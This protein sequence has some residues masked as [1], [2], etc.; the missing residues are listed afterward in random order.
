MIESVLCP[1]YTDMENNKSNLGIFRMT[2]CHPLAWLF[3]GLLI[4]NTATHAGVEIISTQGRNIYRL[5]LARTGSSPKG[6]LI[7][8]STFD[9]R[10]CAFSLSGQ[11]NWDANTGGFVYDL[12]TGD[13][14]CDGSDEIVA[15]S[16]DGLVYVHNAAGAR[17]WTVDLKAPVYQVAIAK[18]DGKTPVVLAGG[19]SRQLVALS[20]EGK[21]LHSV[22]IKDAV[23]IIRSGDFNG[24]G[25]DEVAVLS[26][27]E[28][29]SFLHG[30]MLSPVNGAMLGKPSSSSLTYGSLRQANGT[31]AD[32]DGDGA[33]EFIYASGAYSLKKGVQRHFI[34]PSRFREASY[35]YH[36]NMRLLASGELT[37]QPGLETVALEG[38]QIRLFDGVGKE[39]GRTIAPFGFTDVIYLPGQP[40][41]SILLGSSPNGD[42]NL[43]RLDF[44]PGW[45]QALQ[46]IERR[47]VMQGI[48]MQLEK[49]ATETIRWKGRKMIG[50][51]GPFDVVLTHA[52]M[53]AGWRPESF[54]SWIAAVR[55]ETKKFPYPNLRFAASFW[56]GE[57]APLLRPDGKPW[58]RDHR[59][60]HRVTRAQ[61]IEGAKI[62]EAAGCH[63]WV[64][65][66][67]G[68][69][70]HLELA[71]IAAILEAAP[72]S[73]RGFITTED[74]RPDE[75]AYYYEHFCRPVLEM[76]LAYGKKFMLHNKNVW[77]AYWPTQETMRKNIFNDRYRSV[78][79][80]CV[81]DSNSRS[82]DVN[83]AG[84]VGLWL[85]G[86][87]ETWACRSIADLFSFNRSWEWEYVMTGHPHLR[88]QI[89][90]AL[91]GA[92][93][94]MMLTGERERA[95]NS[96]T[97]TGTEG[98]AAFLHLLGKGVITPPRREQLQS[99]SPVA[100]TMLSPSDRFI[101][102]GANGH[103]DSGWNRDGTD[104]KTW[105]FDRLDCY[106]GMA[107]LPSTDVATYLWGRARR[108]ASQLPVTTPHGFVAILNEEKTRKDQRWGT[109]WHTDGDRLWKSDRAYCLASAGDSIQRDL[110]AMEKR[111]PFHVEG[112]VTHHVI[113]QTPDEFI[114]ALIDPGWTAP[115]ERSVKISTRLDGKWRAW[116]RLS[117]EEIGNLSRPLE[118]K[119]PAGVFRLLDV[120]RE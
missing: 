79:L 119:V 39:L 29:V 7:I 97:R 15:A 37:Q 106:W 61:I 42:D 63:F 68:C 81:E 50:A 57:K 30:T 100:L 66:G 35:D 62:F 73:L 114:I 95:S 32:I 113:E 71:T 55:D 104:E 25:A 38:A 16:A 59:L 9:N 93:V 31:V 45:Q 110:V 101:H 84:R 111:L 77:W 60:A 34:M 8:G 17:L 51:E 83:L 69:G 41:G 118:V 80:P 2:I 23:R 1:R 53:W 40:Y 3:I 99:I 70:P 103:A 47:G 58:S 86:Q 90:Q 4:A 44:A 13:L 28:T 56:T 76:C 116:D 115:S 22:D 65:I 78:L 12:A 107:P 85:S 24:D 74:E 94:F 46:K 112:T 67:H 105:A 26:R 109:T 19:V 20:A 82:A 88:Y 43:Y 18:L 48:G 75:I 11:Y 91:F 14:N 21:R 98:T 120:R 96:W 5:A 117:G 64:Q 52:N 6:A 92:S 108:D 102:H 72:N 87:V 27:R 10:I 49:V 33:E 89:S 54:K 36:Y